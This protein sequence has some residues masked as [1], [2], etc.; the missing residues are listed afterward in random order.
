M[1][2]MQSLFLAV[3]LCTVLTDLGAAY[4]EGWA[5]RS[6]MAQPTP[7]ESLHLRLVQLAA[8]VLAK[9]LRA[10]FGLVVVLVAV[11]SADGPQEM[12]ISWESWGTLFLYATCL[13]LSGRFAEVTPGRVQCVGVCWQMLAVSPAVFPWDSQ[14]FGLVHD[15]HFLPVLVTGM[16]LDFKK[17]MAL[18]CIS[19][20][21]RAFV[22]MFG[23]V[24]QGQTVEAQ[25]T[26]LL[27]LLV[28]DFFSFLWPASCACVIDILMKDG[29]GL[30]VGT[31]STILLEKV[32]EVNALEL[33]SRRI[34]A[35]LSDAT[36]M[37]DSDLGITGSTA[38][39]CDLLASDGVMR[40]PVP[41]GGSFMAFLEKEEQEKLRCFIEES[42]ADATKV[43]PADAANLTLG[44]GAEKV[45]IEL[46]H[47]AVHTKTQK[48]KHLIAIRA[49]TTIKWND[50]EGRDLEEELPKV[51]P[52]S[53]PW[54]NNAKPH[55]RTTSR[56]SQQL[57]NLSRTSVRELPELEKICL[58]LDITTCKLTVK[59]FQLVF[60]ETGELPSFIDFLAPP[61]RKPLAAWLRAMSIEKLAGAPVTFDKPFDF[62][63]PGTQCTQMMARR[64]RLLSIDEQQTGKG[65]EDSSQTTK[66]PDSP[67]DEMEDIQ[68]LLEDPSLAEDPEALEEVLAI[69]EELLHR[70]LEEMK[71]EMEDL[72][73]EPAQAIRKIAR[74]ELASILQC[75]RSLI[76]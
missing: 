1:I 9:G 52:A 46:F 42:S 35:A 3:V 25:P 13:L 54:I 11:K 31:A 59:S 72:E 19:L 20:G 21:I 37:L 30:F 41:A 10:L 74:L 5:H 61:L 69:H 18:N 60:T 26:S 6:G 71:R 32:E 66:T 55:V 14:G 43:S 58:D 73:K 65:T 45:R 51:D 16:M 56:I 49:N 53:S 2:E 8:L 4:F 39:I 28:S 47:A 76:A 75:S 17:S 29:A 67:H 50:A 7:P 63:V 68:R 44:G 62:K 24:L 34:L 70:R 38:K 12:V 64:V 15:L 40:N 22:H 33:A 57:S 48:A 27:C 36:V 23:F